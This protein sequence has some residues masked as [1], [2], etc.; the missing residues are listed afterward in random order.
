MVNMYNKNNN[1]LKSLRNILLASTAFGSLF[2][3]SAFAV[4]R[5]AINNMSRISQP[6][7]WIGGVAPVAGDN[8]I[9][10]GFDTINF[11]GNIN[12]NNIN[13]YGF[14]GNTI[15]INHDCSIHNITNDISPAAR[16]LVQAANGGVAVPAGLGINAKSII[17]FE[18]NHKSLTITGNDLRGV[19]NIILKNNNNSLIFDSA[20]IVDAMIYSGGNLWSTV[21]ANKNVTFNN[22]IGDDPINGAKSIFRLDIDQN[23]SVTIKNDIRASEI[24]L[25][26]NN[27]ELI[28]DPSLNN[29]R[30]FSGINFFEATGENEGKINIKGHAANTVTITGQIGDVDLR[31]SKI[32]IENGKSTTFGQAVFAKKIEIAQNTVIFNDNVNMVNAANGDRGTLEF[33]GN[34]TI[35]IADNKS[36]RGNIKTAANHTGNISFKGISAVE[37][38]GELNARVAKATTNNGAIAF[39]QA[40]YADRFDVSGNGMVTINHRRLSTDQVLLNHANAHIVHNGLNFIYFYKNV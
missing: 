34:G 21:I 13:L 23:S 28:V 27:S 2:A 19:G 22:K 11:D 40:I 31:L 30:V 35:E 3:E 1:K 5:L 15:E 26:T 4:N 17:S 36:I 38:I 9:F 20:I 8:L 6:V 33:T 12:I 29:I 14:D 39:N 10:T 7:H 18:T 37:Q 32:T 24:T 16:A 25:L